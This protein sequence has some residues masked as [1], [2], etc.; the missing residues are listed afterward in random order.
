MTAAYCSHCEVTFILTP[1]GC[2]PSCTSPVA[3]RLHSKYRSP[4]RRAGGI[5]IASCL[6]ALLCGFHLASL[7]N[8][9]HASYM[10]A[11][12]MFSLIFTSF[13]LHDGR[14]GT[15]IVGFIVLTV[16]CAA[17]GLSVSRRPS[18]YSDT[19]VLLLTGG[20]CIGAGYAVVRPWFAVPGFFVGIFA[21][22]TVLLLGGA[23]GDILAYWRHGVS[24]IRCCRHY[25]A[26]W[27]GSWL[28]CVIAN[29]LSR[30]ILERFAR[31][32]MRR[33]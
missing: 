22:G 7:P 29:S 19:F 15:A 24:V 20:M 30:K 25:R 27:S 1:D 4:T 32:W 10:I 33:E 12:V 26:T 14:W 21:V 11:P 17:A 9:H 23:A 13:P 31:C 18:L 6:A 3:K 28:C 16:L 5:V 8:G 2:C